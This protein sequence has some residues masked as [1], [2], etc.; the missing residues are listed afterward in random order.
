MIRRNHQYNNENHIIFLSKTNRSSYQNKSAKQYLYLF[1]DSNNFNILKILPRNFKISTNTSSGQFNTELLKDTSS[2][3]SNHLKEN[4]QSLEYHLDI[5]D[6]DN[7]LS[8][9]EEM[10]QGELVFFDED[11]LPISKKITSFLNIK[12]CP[13]YLKPERLK[14]KETRLECALEDGVQISSISLY[15]FLRNDIFKTFKIITKRKEYTCNSFGVYYSQIIRE[16]LIQDSTISSCEYDINDDFNEFQLICDLLNFESI[17][18]TIDNVHSLRKMADDLQINSVLQ[19]IDDKINEC[20]KVS[21]SIDEQQNNIEIIEELFGWL[22][23][24]QVLTVE[25]V[26]KSILES[27]WCE[28][29]EDV[30]ELAAFILQVIKTDPILH[31]FLADLIIQLDNEANDENSLKI[32]APF[33]IKKLISSLGKTSNNCSF[34]YHLFKRGLIQKDELF[35]QIKIQLRPSLSYSHKR[36]QI[37]SNL[38]CWF[39][40]ELIE[41]DLLNNS[42]LP[43]GMH[44][45]ITED[46]PDNTIDDFIDDQL[47][48][49][50]T[51]KIKYFIQLYY[52]DKMELF[53][54]MRDSGEPNDELTKS[55]RN[56][57]VDTLQS[58]VTKRETN[59]SK[60]F[61]PFNLFEQFVQNGGTSYINYAA[62]YGSIKCFK[63]L[64][65]NHATIDDSTFKYAL[66]GGNIEIIKIVDQQSISTENKRVVQ[67]QRPPSKYQNI[68]TLPSIMKHSNDLFDWV[69]ENK[70]STKSKIE[71]FSHQMLLLSAK[72]GNAHSFTE[73]VDK[74]IDFSVFYL[75]VIEKAAKNGFYHLTKLIYDINNRKAK[76]EDFPAGQVRPRNENKH[77]F[78]SF[79][80]LSIFKLFLQIPNASNGLENSLIYAVKKEYMNIIKFFFDDLIKKEFNISQRGIYDTLEISL[81]KKTNDLFIFLKDQFNLAYPS[82]FKKFDNLEEL[83]NKACK[84]ENIE[85]VEILTDMILEKNPNEDFVMQFFEA[86]SKDSLEICQYFVDKKVFINYERLSSFAFNIG[87]VNCEIFSIMINNSTEEIKDRFIRTFLYPAI[88]SHNMELV[89]FLL[90]NNAP[91][92]NALIKAVNTD[93]S[94][95][96]D[97]ILKY[98]SKPSFINKKSKNGTALTIAVSHNN[99][100]IVKRLL[101]LPG[102][103][104]NLYNK[105]DQT[106]LILA[107]SNFNFEILNAILEFYGDDIESQKWQVDEAVKE[108]LK[109]I[110]NNGK[111]INT[112]HWDLRIIENNDQRIRSVLKRLLEIKCVNPNCHCNK[113]TLLSYACERNE[114]DIVKMLLNIDKT[115]VNTYAPE[116]GNTPLMIAI[117]SKHVEIAKLLIN[118]QRTNINIR[119][120]DNQTALTFASRKKLIEIIDLLISNEKFD[121]E[122]SSLNFAFFIS[123]NEIASKLFNLK[124]LDVNY[125]AIDNDIDHRLNISNSIYYTDRNK[126]YETALTL[127]TSKS[128]FYMV[129]LIVNHHSF[130]PITSQLKKAIFN[131]VEKQNFKMFEILIKLPYVDINMAT[132]TMSLLTCSALSKSREIMNAIL[133]HPNFDPIKSSIYDTFIKCATKIDEQNNRVVRPIPYGYNDDDNDDND[134]DDNDNENDGDSVFNILEDLLQYDQKHSH[135]IDCNKLLPNGKSFFTLKKNSLQIENYVDFFIEH[136]ADPNIP[137]KEGIYPLEHAIKL[138]S[139]GFVSSLIE[140]EKVDLNQ[141]IQVKNSSSS[142]DGNKSLV[143]YLHIAAE[144]TNDHILKIFL[145]NDLLD[146]NIVDDLGETPLMHACRFKKKANI[147]LLFEKDDLDYLHCNNEGDDALMIAHKISLSTENIETPKNKEDYFNKLI[148]EINLINKVDV[149][150]NYGRY[151]EENIH[152]HYEDYDF[153]D[154][155]NYDFSD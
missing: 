12:N 88:V 36:D 30:H 61:V 10:Y 108:A 52:P 76:D 118:D 120:Y 22:Y 34:V 3:I 154:N 43:N 124:D 60:S 130:N 37:V 140:S 73:I 24:I 53:K 85:A 62:A 142:N 81:S 147:E 121:P 110:S 138:N 7:I 148:K 80:N 39:L 57:D 23:K 46:D 79:G 59:F 29:E 28:T 64:L 50:P 15:D 122:E 20:E 55:L 38:Y 137:D 32:L 127:A 82:I 97:I 128:D 145:S 6:E 102:I 83:L 9:F 25:T 141:K 1:D 68:D 14:I 90:K 54:K 58:I 63:Y 27:F 126:L 132:P 131:C 67:N 89:E 51:N 92:E 70:Y 115:D 72:N 151:Y 75:Q 31:P 150:Y 136:G 16:L 155:E 134:G 106:P 144:S 66:F 4:P 17:E 112:N 84:T 2:I 101:S 11:D 45:I 98:N 40:P 143:S 56:D 44:T 77:P 19:K 41:M 42:I 152:Y 18:M 109:I 103:N 153:Y 125:V 107:V 95:I 78:V 104:V 129:N 69:L 5:K 93:D 99:L 21:K 96:V 139:K 87:S 26:A 86:A 49:Y 114:I 91:F 35:S 146:V 71:N 47:P 65:L 133:A 117:E 113:Y 8:K 111:G 33:L 48:E 123:N 149:F 13:N 119:N 100:D 105:E 94:E 74:G 116:N 135:L